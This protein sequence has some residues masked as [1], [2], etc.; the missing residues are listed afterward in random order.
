MTIL[1]AV[2]LG[3]VIGSFLNVCIVRLPADESIVA[4]GSHCRQGD[5]AI[6]WHDNI[7]VAS[8][9]VLR[10]RCRGCG[11]RISG[12]YPLVELL[13][14]ALFGLVAMQHLP[15]AELALQM[16]IVSAMIVIT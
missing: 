14:A 16:A 10:G 5:A 3:L 8:Y 2:L 11:E 4:P 7:P 13:T 15:P 9:L 6:A 1:A 12:R